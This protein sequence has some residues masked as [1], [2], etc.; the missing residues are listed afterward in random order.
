MRRIPADKIGSSECL[1]VVVV[2]NTTTHRI[3]LDL[4]LIDLLAA[5]SNLRWFS[6][7]R[8]A[9][10][11]SVAG[12]LCLIGRRTP[13][14]STASLTSYNF[15]ISSLLPSA[16]ASTPSRLGAESGAL[17]IRLSSW[18]AR[19]AGSTSGLSIAATPSGFLSQAGSTAAPLTSSTSRKSDAKPSSSTSSSNS[20]RRPLALP[21]ATCPQSQTTPDLEVA[22]PPP[23]PTPSHPPSSSHTAV[24]SGEDGAYNEE[25]DTST[26]DAGHWP[27]LFQAAFYA[28]V[29]CIRPLLVAQHASGKCI[30]YSRPTSPSPK[31]QHSPSQSDLSTYSSGSSRGGGHPTMHSQVGSYASH[32]SSVSRRS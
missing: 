6:G 12:C 11:L 26:P 17:A 2:P 23:P 5:Q 27:A 15:A 22:Y 7:I 24:V 9:I 1:K 19:L 10:L 29:W 21:L 16:L 8:V 13:A 30:E 25:N 4:D 32:A 3:T 14:A 31:M 20:R 18:L 28:T